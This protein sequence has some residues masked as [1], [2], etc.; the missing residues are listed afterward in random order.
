M[1]VC[2][3]GCGAIGGLLAARLAQTGAAVSVIARGGQLEAIR[4]RGLTLIDDESEH[5][6]LVIP[7]E[8]PTSIGPQDLVI[9]AMKAHTVT[10]VA[11]KI[12]SLLG[13]DTAVMTACNGIPWWYFHGLSEVDNAPE[14]K[15][16]DPGRLL[17]NNIGPERAIGCVVY[18]AARIEQPGIV[19]HMFG[20][21]FTLGEP[22][23][24]RSARIVRVSALFEAAG[25]E[26]PVEQNIR[27]DIWTKLVANAALNP[28]SVITGKTLGGMLDDPATRKLLL[29][30]M[31][32]IEA[33]AQALGIETALDAAQLLE[34]TQQLA[35]HKTSM[36][37]DYEAGRSLELEPIAG[38]VQELA[39]IYGVA[40][41]NLTMTCQ[42]VR[43]KLGQASV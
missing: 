22:D 8:D 43:N 3:Y 1:K 6:A 21:A 24:S 19:R 10:D 35:A 26:A 33:V 7:A 13:P 32:E 20:N 12:F 40:T 42:L 28:V 9:L 17:W 34:A 36:L 2:V 31:Q 14:L 37:N 16:V 39:G 29:Q 18:P 41:P 11:P 38:A 30:I 4:A 5:Q 25:F 23:G 27:R 15:S